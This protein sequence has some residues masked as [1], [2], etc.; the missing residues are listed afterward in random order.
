MKRYLNILWESKITL[1]KAFILFFIIGL[2]AGTPNSIFVLALK[3]ILFG[4]ILITIGI[5]F[6]KWKFKD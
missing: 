1:L 3:S 4:T 6:T 5:V 2:I